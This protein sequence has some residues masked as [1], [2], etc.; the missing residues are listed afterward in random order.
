MAASLTNQGD[1]SGQAAESAVTGQPRWLARPS[2]D[3][4]PA[5]PVFSWEFLPHIE[6]LYQSKIILESNHPR[7][8]EA[9]GQISI[10]SVVGCAGGLLADSLAEPSLTVAAAPWAASC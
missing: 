9:L 10:Y 3:L 2:L 1:E 5:C 7:R 8:L 6:M 4:W